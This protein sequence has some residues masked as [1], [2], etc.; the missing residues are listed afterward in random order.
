MAPRKE[1]SSSYK[2]RPARG[3][4]SR[5][6]R[7]NG[8]MA[9]VDRSVNGERT[10]GSGGRCDHQQGKYPSGDGSLGPPARSVSL[11]AGE[12]GGE[13]GIFEH[14][15]LRPAWQPQAS[16]IAYRQRPNGDGPLGDRETGKKKPNARWAVSG[17]PG[18]TKMGGGPSLTPGF[19]SPPCLP[20]MAAAA[21]RRASTP[22][23]F[24][25]GPLGVGRFLR[26]RGRPPY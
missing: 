14:D 4:L 6:C 23:R 18:G 24:W 16:G 13:S 2:R 10:P 8:A 21:A 19:G 17:P 15:L 5:G 9:G 1:V 26:D 12:S 7:K 22:P 20:T 11:R 3:E 25:S